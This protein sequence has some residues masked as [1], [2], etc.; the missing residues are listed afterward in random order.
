MESKE[1]YLI[2]R[3][4]DRKDAKERFIRTIGAVHVE[5]LEISQRE[6]ASHRDRNLSR[7]SAYQTA[8]NSEKEVINRILGNTEVT[9]ERDTFVSERV[10]LSSARLIERR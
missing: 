10:Q 5:T 4:P 2:C 9:R 7:V 8:T 6:T 1:A 3:Q